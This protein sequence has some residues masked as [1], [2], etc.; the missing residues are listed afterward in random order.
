M[1]RTVSSSVR[2][3]ALSVSVSTLKLQ[4]LREQDMHLLGGVSPE[5]A[6]LQSIVALDWSSRHLLRDQLEQ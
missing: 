1:Y 5:T 4:R 2:E 3:S 6:D